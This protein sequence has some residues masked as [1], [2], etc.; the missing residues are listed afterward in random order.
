MSL[1]IYGIHPVLE[2]LRRRPHDFRRIV[3]ARER[4]GDDAREIAARAR[5]GGITVARDSMAGIDKLCRSEHHQGVAAEVAAFPLEEC[6]QVIAGSR[7][8]EQ[9]VFFLVLDTIQD[10]HNFGALIRSAVCC[11]VQAVIFPKDRAATLTGTVAKASAGAIEH[12]TLCRVVNI[13]ATLELLKKEGVWI[14][15]TDAAGG[16]SIYDFDFK[17]D[18]ALVIGSEGKG[19]RPLVRKKCDFS[20]A[21]PMQGSFN[22]LNASAAGAVV[23]FEAMRQRQLS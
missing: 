3:I 6:S 21:V 15:G 2:A 22:S 19:I 5:K 18:M 7:K 10:P 23:L 4:S 11:G 14:V 9:P 1:F 8:L 12:I 16:Q 13:A 17:L 20:L